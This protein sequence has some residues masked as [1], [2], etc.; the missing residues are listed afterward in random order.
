VRMA[1]EGLRASART[2]RGRPPGERAAAPGLSQ[3]HPGLPH[4]AQEEGFGTSDDEER[5]GP[6]LHKGTVLTPSLPLL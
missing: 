2:P 5:G 4:T 6:P 1:E 3:T